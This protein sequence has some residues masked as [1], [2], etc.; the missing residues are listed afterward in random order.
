MRFPLPT[1]LKKRRHLMSEGQSVAQWVIKK[2]SEYEVAELLEKYI[3]FVDEEGRSVHC[4]SPFV[5]HFMK[6]QDGTLPLLVAIST[7]PLVLAD[8]VM[9]APEGLDRKRGIAFL[10]E[11]K[12]RKCL[13]HGRVED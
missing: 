9:L 6:R 8:G 13:P 3:D 4:R 11:P 10:I 1:D 2:M 5:G 12:I 7:L